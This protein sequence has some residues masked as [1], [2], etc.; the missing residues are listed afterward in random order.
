MNWATVIPLA[1][2]ILYNVLLSNLSYSPKDFIKASKINLRIA[3]N[4]ESE[5][6][7]I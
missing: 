1:T 6:A 3:S 5:I 4:P 7:N 2:S